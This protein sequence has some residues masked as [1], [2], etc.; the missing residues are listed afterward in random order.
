M[1]NICYLILLS[2]ILI[3]SC[4]EKKKENRFRLPN[5]FKDK[6]VV[7]TGKATREIFYR[8]FESNGKLEAHRKAEILFETN[9]C[10]TKISVANGD[11]VKKGAPLSCM[12]SEEEQ[13]SYQGAKRSLAKSKL[14]LEDV[15]INM[16][17]QFKDSAN[18][19][20]QVMKVALIRSGYEDAISSLKMA[21]IKLDKTHIEAPF[22]GIVADM[23]AKENNRSGQYK[24]L[25]TL[26]D[27]S[28]FEVSF[29]L[30]E[31]EAFKLKD[32][33]MI[34][35][36][37][38]AFDGDTIIG[39]L[40]EVNPHVDETGMVNAKAIIDNKNGRLAEG[41]N[42]KVI[43]REAVGERTIVPKSA[44]TL[45]QERKV[46][47]VCKNDTAHWRYV[48]IGEENSKFCTIIDNSIKPNE[49]VVVDG[50][51]NLAHLVPVTKLN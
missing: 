8:E 2:F 39:K 15:L 44:V 16:G 46:V 23:E 51:F 32:G 26:I 49:E 13:L 50:N 47:F 41:M 36:I 43:I 34:A 27:N 10:I 19:P 3:T 9:K 35:A 22:S 28:Q 24:K 11:H 38:Y 29:P 14:N 21:Q 40:T 45:R 1:K 31:S 25:C 20:P 6:N 7:A 33:A 4:K 12:K 17:Y 18:I 37:P 30:L 42:V 48:K 5:Q